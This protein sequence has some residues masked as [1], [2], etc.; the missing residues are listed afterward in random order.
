MRFQ[1]DTQMKYVINHSVIFEVSTRRLILVANKHVFVELSKPGT[2]LLL[3]LIKSNKIALTRDYLLKHVWEDYGF[4]SSSAILSNHI[5]ELRRAFISIDISKTSII[6]VPRSGFKLD[7]DVVLMCTDE[8]KKE[9]TYN[10]DTDTD[11]TLSPVINNTGEIKTKCFYQYLTSHWIFSLTVL[12]VVMV[13]CVVKSYSLNIASN[14]KE[15]YFMGTE[16]KC[17]IYSLNEI[18]FY[19]KQLERVKTMILTNN[20]NCSTTKQNVYYTEARP[21][22]DRLNV[23]FMAACTSLDRNNNRYCEN[24]KQVK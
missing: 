8:N 12:T 23:S 22:N 7:T 15:I 17:S 10:V 2:R 9:E 5:S 16:G 20:I 21:S 19:L 11:T 1:P 24:F 14:R 3:E 4:S 18:Q 6:T 13:L